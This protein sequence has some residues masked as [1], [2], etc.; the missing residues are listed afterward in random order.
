MAKEGNIQGCKILAK[1][2][3]QL[4][5]Q[6][7]RT[8]TATSKIQGIGYQNKA[9]GANA[10]LAGAMGVAGKTMADMNRLMKPEQIAATLNEFGKQSMKMDMT[11]EMS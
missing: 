3:I 5:K 1:Q 4:R 2:L 9:M 7:T 11:E 8:F 6:K 10:K